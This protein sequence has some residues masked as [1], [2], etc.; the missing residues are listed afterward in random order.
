MDMYGTNHS[1][2]AQKLVILLAECVLIGISYWVLFADGLLAVRA[3][4]TDP[5][6][7]RNLTL[8]AF[9]LIVFARFLLTLFVFLRR[10]IPWEET[11]SVP[12]AFGL[13]L[14]G[15]PLMARSA[16]VPFGALEVGGIVLFLVGSF[17]NTF[18]EWQRHRWKA[19]AENRGRLYTRGLFAAAIHINY[20]GDV[21]W[22]AG[23]ACVTHNAYA[24]LVPAF[25][26]VFFQFF[27]VPKLDAYLRDRYGDDFAAYERRT[28]R[29]I[30]FVL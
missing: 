4:G 12:M 7:L 6:R 27:N 13:Y 19:R 17:L 5:S 2:T 22:V 24:A 23:Y 20:F 15:F 3:F 11:L 16:A 8:L 21:L 18:S 14:L 9:N 1:S 30:P 29:L 10:R 25:L 28:K 26:F